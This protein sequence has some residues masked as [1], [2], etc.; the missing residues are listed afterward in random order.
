[1]FQKLMNA[2]FG[3][4]HERNLKELLPIL[5]RINA[6]ESETMK[7]KN[8]EFPAKTAEFKSRLAAGESLD[9]LLP[10]SFALVREGRP[11]NAG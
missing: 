9:E 8:E 6:L 4:Q 1:M 3:S 5:H 10:E 2:I 11:K 7:L